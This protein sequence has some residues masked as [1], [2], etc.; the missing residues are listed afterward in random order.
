MNLKEKILSALS[1]S[2]AAHVSG[3]QL[4]ARLHVS[5]TA[6]WKYIASLEEN[7]YIIEAVPSKGYRLISAPDT[8]VLE[9]VKRG[10]TTRVIGHDIRLLPL[11]DSTNTLAMEFAG[12][13]A[14][15]GT[16][17]LAEQQR[18]GKGRL[19]RTWI[20][21]RGNLY[22]SVILR[23]GIPTHK[24]PLLTLLGATAACSAIR[25]Q[26]DLP[27]GIKWP[28][29]I[30][31]AGK[32]TGG[33]LTEM[34][35]EPDRIR[36]IVLGIGINVNMELSELPPDIRDLSTS[37]S[38]HA[39][40]KI[41]RTALLR[42]LL[43]EL[44]QRYRRFLKSETDVLDEWRKLNVTLGNR[45]AVKAPDGTFEGLA[46]SIDREGRLIVRM[47]QGAPRIVASGDVTLL[48]RK[49]GRWGGR[50]QAR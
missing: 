40:R 2:E 13:G 41:D 1:G 45:V 11:V 37:L 18:G 22:L 4:A 26:L 7:G 43:S 15:E 42:R 27:A 50:P 21:P 44:D 28:N 14:P 25:K 12:Q 23:P 31:L 17:V 33:L 34:S 8:I 6:V 9:T 29:D 20:S 32:K 49:P 39:G 5:R 36:H 48:K 47:E 16:V 19:G 38:T 30:L 46:E 3:A 10:L 35:A 24:A